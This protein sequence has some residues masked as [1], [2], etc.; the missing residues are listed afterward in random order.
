MKSGLP[1]RTF[2]LIVSP[3]F[4]AGGIWMIASGEPSGWGGTVFFG[5]CLLVAIFEPWLPDPTR[6]PVYRLVITPHEVACEHPKRPRE[7]IRWEDVKRVWYVTT[8]D[9]PWLPDEWILLEGE[10]G[11]CS[12]PTEAAGFDGIWDELKQR[13]PGFDYESFLRGGTDDARYLCWERR[14]EPRREEVGGDS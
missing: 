8:S 7:S 2:T 11:G 10:S 13:F 1:M 9:G 6:T 12:F 14:S 4:I 5:L 3:L